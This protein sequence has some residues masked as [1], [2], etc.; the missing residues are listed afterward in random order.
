MFICWISLGC[1]LFIDIAK[2]PEESFHMRDSAKTFFIE[3]FQNP[4]ENK[5]Y[6]KTT[7]A[8]DTF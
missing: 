3:K 7:Q 5:N 2:L 1:I 4:T 8:D 6:H